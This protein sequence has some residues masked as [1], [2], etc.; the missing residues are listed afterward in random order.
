MR[1]ITIL[2]LCLLLLQVLGEDKSMTKAK[3]N[4]KGKGKG[5]G[6]KPK[7]SK[8]TTP[9]PTTPAVTE[10]PPFFKYCETIFKWNFLDF[11]VIKSIV[12]AITERLDSVCNVTEMQP[13]V[14]NIV[15]GNLYCSTDLPTT[16]DLLL[17][18]VLDKVERSCQKLKDF[19]S[20][21]I[22]TSDI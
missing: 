14:P 22:Y 11:E 16:I 13:L 2:L 19:H 5:K 18:Y 9:P 8:G 4:N 20:L 17:D 10:I 3:G 12:K 15:A 7:A 6:N 1:V 21:F